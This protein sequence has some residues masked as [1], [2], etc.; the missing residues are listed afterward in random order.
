MSVVIDCKCGA[1]L[2]LPEQPTGRAFRCPQCKSGIALGVDCRALAARPWGPRDGQASCPICQSALAAGELVVNC[3]EC[4]QIHHLEC[5]AEIGGCGTYGC[6]QAPAV[7]KGPATSPPL[8]AWGDTKKC[9]V[10][11]ETIKAIAVKCR[12]CRTSFGTADPLTLRDMHRRDQRKKSRGSLATTVW[13]LFGLTILLGC[14]APLMLIV[15]C[16]ML[17]PKRKEIAKAG[18]IYLVLAYTAITISVLYSIL[19]ISFL[20]FG[21]GF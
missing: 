13:V 4:Q 11:G 18:P 8:S 20:I 19:V 7:K 12:Y 1:Q 15:D 2:Q 16:A 17:L 3:P 9:P 14:V 6:K 21:G 5:W 10:C